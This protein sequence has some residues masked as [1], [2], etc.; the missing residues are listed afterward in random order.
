MLS[1][2]AGGPSGA[3]GGRAASPCSG[4]RRAAPSEHQRA[5]ERAAGL[6]TWAEA[7]QRWASGG[8][9]RAAALS[10]PRRA[11]WERKWCRRNILGGLSAEA[12]KGVGRKLAHAWSS[13]LR[14]A[15]DFA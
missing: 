13:G 10:C 11:G 5:S 8:Q 7:R 6:R 3:P 2:K 14:F 1:R 4:G 15:V 12:G 9:V